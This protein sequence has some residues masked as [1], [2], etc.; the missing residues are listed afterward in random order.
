MNT[1]DRL[2]KKHQEIENEIEDKKFVTKCK[3]D[4]YKIIVNKYNAKIEKALDKQNQFIEQ[5]KLELDK[6]SKLIIAEAE[7]AKK[8][9][10]KHTEKQ[11]IKKS[12]EKEY[13]KEVEAI[14][15]EAKA[16]GLVK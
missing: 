13:K 5:K 2:E 15:K 6:N 8:L 4:K 9:G 7:Y 10:T 14:K 1:I 11:K 3:T 12:K 16:K